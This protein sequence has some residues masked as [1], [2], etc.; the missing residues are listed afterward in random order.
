AVY[1]SFLFLTKDYANTIKEGEEVLKKEPNNTVMNRLMAYAYYETDQNDK[2]LAAIQNYFKVVPSNKYIASDYEY[3]G[4]ILSKA[5]KNDEALEN[6]NKALEMD[7]TR[8][9]LRNSIAQV[10]VKQNNFPK[11]IA[12]Y[13][14]KMKR[15]KPT[16]T[17]YYYLGNL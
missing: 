7:S 1:S 6:L 16:N 15:S 9:D 12:L 13:R 17:D 11:A 4:K 3:Y 14:A 10:Y 5:N 2:A 8:A